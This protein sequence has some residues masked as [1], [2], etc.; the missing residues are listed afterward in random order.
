MSDNI[1]DSAGVGIVTAYTYS[2][3]TFEIILGTMIG[4][5]RM[6]E[7]KLY[8]QF[9]NGSEPGVFDCGAMIVF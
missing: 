8:L 3:R 6:N 1:L 5:R 2:T 4:G 7:D 9:R